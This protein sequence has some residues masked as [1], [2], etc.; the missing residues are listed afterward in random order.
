M[1][2]MPDL[3]VQKKIEEMVRRIAERF[4][5]EKIILFGSHARGTAGPDSDVDLL[6]VMR[7]QGS[8][9]QKATEIDLSLADREMPLDLL[10]VTP[11]QFDRERD[12]I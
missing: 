6:V 8:R 3:A 5:P 7:V 11:E 4:H 9:R 1:E 2:Q 10:V 12:I